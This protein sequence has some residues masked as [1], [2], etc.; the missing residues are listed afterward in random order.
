MRVAQTPGA[1]AALASAFAV[2]SE[3]PF[4]PF[5]KECGFNNLKIIFQK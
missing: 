5:Y 1:A 2:R 4:G 3:P